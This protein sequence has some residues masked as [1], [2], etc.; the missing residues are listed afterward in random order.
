M[1]LAEHFPFT[2]QGGIEVV[3]VGSLPEAMHDL[4]KHD[5]SEVFHQLEASNIYEILTDVP[6][7]TFLRDSRLDTY[8]LKNDYEAYCIEERFDEW[9]LIPLCFERDNDHNISD[10]ALQ[11]PS[12]IDVD[13]CLQI[14]N[15]S[16]NELTPLRRI[17]QQ[18]DGVRQRKNNGVQKIRILDTIDDCITDREAQIDSDHKEHIDNSVGMIKRVSNTR[19]NMDLVQFKIR[20][21]LYI[22]MQ[23][24]WNFMIDK[25]ID[26]CL[27]VSNKKASILWRD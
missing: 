27:T 20:F 4:L 21:G 18:Q 7:M 8:M 25:Y 22:H 14:Q 3:C 2:T 9:D 12:M 15:T 11:R 5:F 10:C 16:D 19:R 23:A 1:D 26:D 13:L 24:F 17:R 6:H